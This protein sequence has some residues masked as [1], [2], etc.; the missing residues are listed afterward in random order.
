MS[1]KQKL[2]TKKWRENNKEHIRKYAKEYR[3]RYYKEKPWAKTMNYI[4]AR[5]HNRE[6]RYYKRGIKCLITVEELKQLW[7][8][9]KAHN[10]ECPSIDRKDNDGNYTFENCRYIEKIENSRLGNILDCATRYEG[11]RL[12]GKWS[13]I[14]G[15]C[16]E[17]GTTKK[18]HHCLGY[19]H[20]CY[21]RLW[22]RKTNNV[23]SPYIKG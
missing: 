10:L 3:K 23:K 11:M 9:D 21:A 20:T 7:F 22:N 2:A 17:C 6:S 18:P 1:N 14:Y 19:C 15:K 13:M 12:K 16:R 8:R 5:C 4:T